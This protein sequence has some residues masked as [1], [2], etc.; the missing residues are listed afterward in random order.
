MSATNLQ[1][2]NNSSANVMPSFRLTARVNHFESSS[3]VGLRLSHCHLE[4]PIKVTLTAKTD[5]WRSASR[6]YNVKGV[7][8]DI[9]GDIDQIVSR[10]LHA[11]SISNI[12]QLRKTRNNMKSRLVHQVKSYIR[13]L[14]GIE[15]VQ[16]EY[17]VN[18]RIDFLLE[19]NRYFCKYQEV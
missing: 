3:E 10:L 16:D 13:T 18:R 15:N 1:T 5:A 4:L 14:Y 8:Q 2:D 17:E 7:I 9:D 11:S 19:K 12:M 6:Q